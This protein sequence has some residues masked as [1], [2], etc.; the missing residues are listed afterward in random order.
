MFAVDTRLGRT[1]SMLDTALELKAKE[2]KRMGVADLRLGMHTE[3]PTEAAALCHLQILCMSQDCALGRGAD[4]AERGWH[5]SPLP[6]DGS[7]RAR[8]VWIDA[9]HGET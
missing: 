3:V 7:W 5:C 1:A 6:S 8:P 2:E 9:E 4:L